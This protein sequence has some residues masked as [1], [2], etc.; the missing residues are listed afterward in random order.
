MKY[1][2]SSEQARQRAGS[3]WVKDL[4]ASSTW[5]FRLLA[6]PEAAEKFAE[7]FGG[8]H[9]DQ[10]AGWDEVPVPSNWQ[11]LGYAPPCY[12]NLEYPFT[13][14]P[15][16]MAP[17]VPSQNPTGVYRTMF[18]VPSDWLPNRRVHLVFQAVGPAVMVWVDGQFVGYSQDSMSPSEF[19]ITNALLG[20]SSSGGGAS[21]VSSP[22]LGRALL[23]EEGRSGGGGVELQPVS[24]TAA[25]PAGGVSRHVLIA[26]VPTWCDGSYMED[27]DQWW[28]T[29]LHRTVE[30]HS[31]PS[32]CRLTDYVLNP[33]LHIGSTAAQLQIILKLS[34]PAPAGLE[35]HL[36]LL[37][38]D[39]SSAE[40]LALDHISPIREGANT[41][42]SEQLQLADVM[43][44]TAE[45]PALYPLVITLRRKSGEIIQSESTM[46]G[47]RN[48]D[49]VDGQL[50]ING[51]PLVIAGANVHEMHPHRGKA[52]AEDDMLADIRLLK[53]GNF[54]AVRNSHYPHHAQWYELCDKYGLYV[55]DEANIETHGFFLNGMISFLACDSSWCAQFLHRASNMF[56]RSKNHAC[57]IIWSLGNESGYGPNFAACS[58]LIRRADVQQR[59]VQ[60]EGGERHGDAAFMHGDG[61]VPDSDIICPMY[62][63]PH[64]ILP[65]AQAPKEGEIGKKH[66]PVILCEYSHALGN[67][68]GS[69]K[70]YWDLF[71]S[72]APEHRSLQGGFVWEWADGAIKVPLKPEPF[73]TQKN[74]PADQFWLD[75]NLGYGGDFG[76]GSGEGDAHFISDGLLFPDRTPH[77][78]F[79]EFK[80]VQQPVEFHLIVEDSCRGAG[81]PREVHI[82]IQNRY[83]FRSLDHLDLYWSTKDASGGAVTSDMWHIIKGMK[84][85]GE[86]TTTIL[87]PA[88]AP[89]FCDCGQW[90]IIQARQRD[91]ELGVLAGHTVAE[92]TFTVYEPRTDGDRQVVCCGSRPPLRGPAPTGQVALRKQDGLHVVEGPGYLVSF[93]G[94]KIHSL[95]SPVADSEELIVGGSFGPCFWRAPIDNDKFGF[96]EFLPMLATLPVVSTIANRMNVLSVFGEWAALGL[97]DIV[98]RLLSSDWGSDSD[99]LPTFRVQETAEAKGR[100]L[101]RIETRFAFSAEEVSVHIQVTALAVLHHLPTLP[102]IGTKF[103]VPSQFSC[104]AWLGC[105]PTESY[106]DRKVAAD[107]CVHCADVDSQHVDYI[108]PCEN[109]GKADMHWAALTD[110]QKPG[111]GLLMHYK[112]EQAAPPEETPGDAPS[113]RRPASTRGAQFSSTRW[114]VHELEASK[115][116]YEL[117]GR[118]APQERSVKVHID[119]AHSGVGGAG[120]GNL[121]LTDAATQFMINPKES[122]WMYTIAF[123]P[124]T[125]SV[126]AHRGECNESL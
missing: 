56:E 37:H 68:N 74:L 58:E 97:S 115:H 73:W 70:Q 41:L 120:N 124:L 10:G 62:Y 61:Q 18:D 65:L 77:P 40:G 118:K 43:P 47:F 104:L 20:Q 106:P 59:P 48:V 64:L 3:P 85:R 66:R 111:T 1:Y 57:V 112:C 24:G 122:P 80:R 34:S 125:A 95:R 72:S 15:S 46:V 103:E 84:P 32:P 89:E 28:L 50:R 21:A 102:R 14:I 30:L 22:S 82:S 63:G 105:G 31:V 2:S 107:W 7:S 67:S 86:S 121:R 42:E 51:I 13:S 60:Y 87:V 23:A 55:V 79:L 25:S 11:M 83:T 114:A 52:L 38:P 27:Q 44:W 109:G 36:M 96:D 19:D 126:W 100:E 39:S 110:P 12:T 91:A 4:G 98:T 5:R 8:T 16:I 93:R 101:F 75:G 9:D 81:E 54:N 123:R 117:Q 76:P 6:N 108:L 78:A 88:L 33:S 29:G 90:L 53:Q 35:A 116:G 69:L 45:T 94:A 17:A 99:G 92:A 113:T 119:T 71:R 26:A 49:I